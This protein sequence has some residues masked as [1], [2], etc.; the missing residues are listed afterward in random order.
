MGGFNY[1][2]CR[3]NAVMGVMYNIVYITGASCRLISKRRIKLVHNL[4][5]H[6]ILSYLRVLLDTTFGDLPLI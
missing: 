3:G 5:L 6:A 2:E 1:V 4:Y